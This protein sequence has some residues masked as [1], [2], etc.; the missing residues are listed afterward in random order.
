MNDDIPKGCLCYTK[1]VKGEIPKTFKKA[2]KILSKYKNNN[3]NIQDDDILDVIIRLYVAE[4][5]SNAIAMLQRCRINPNFGT[6][7]LRKDLEYFIPQ[8][9]NFMVFHQHLSDDNLIQFVLR[10]SSLDFF[11]AHQVFFQLKSMS[12][13]ITQ[14]EPVT[15]TIV[16]RFTD[17]FFLKMSQNYAG[18]LL[19]ASHIL[20]IDFEEINFNKNNLNTS[21]E[22][23]SPT[24]SS[25]QQVYQGGLRIE[26]IK[27]NDNISLYGTKEWN[28]N[29]NQ[30]SV[31]TAI[32]KNYKEIHLQ[33]YSSIFGKRQNNFDTAFFSN[34]SFWDDIMRICDDLSK[35]KK[36]TEFLH[37]CLQKMNE[38]LPAA[39]YVP[40]VGN[41]IRNHAVLK[42]VYKES[43]VFSTKM[44]SPF[45]LVL[46]LYRPEVEEKTNSQIVEEQISFPITAN[47]NI[48]KKPQER[49]QSHLLQEELKLD[50]IQRKYSSVDVQKSIQNEFMQLKFN[51]SKLPIDQNQL[52]GT[53]LFYC[54]N[55]ESLTSDIEQKDQNEI[56]KYST[57][58]SLQENV[59]AFSIEE[60]IPQVEKEEKDVLLISKMHRNS[61]LQAEKGITLNRDEYNELKRNIFG[62]SSQQQE[63][64]IKS[65][66]I[67]QGLK[68]WR[69]AHLIVKTGDNLKQEQFA[70]QLI[71]QFDQIF[72]KSGLPLKLRC[73][74]VLSLGPDCGII[75]MIKNATT[76]DSLQKNLR[77]KYQQFINFSD[78]FRSFF[79]NNI[80]QALQN[81]VQSLVAYGLVCYFLQVK[82]RHNGNILLDSEGHLIH[83]DFG[84]FLSNAPGKGM[85]FEGKVPFKLL[86]DYIQ[87]LGGAKGVLFKENFRKLFYKGFKACQQH[88][89]EILLLVEMMY[90]GHGTTL[91][92]FQKGEQALKELYARFNPRVKS[93]A[94][95]FV[96][97]QELINHSLDNW[98]ARWYDKFQYFAQ[99]V[100]Y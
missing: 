49:T 87:V 4:N 38:N 73:Y 1:K 89:K 27:V 100:F 46:E 65:Q 37:S 13:I 24:K 67:F 91:P 14:N 53:S 23:S 5:K 30:K 90:T 50:E 20:Q 32:L 45:S 85:E 40:F 2:N 28:K 18:N 95:L 66:S 15:F 55:D 29:D 26:S 94:E 62:E 19:I 68:S 44:R 64:R 98:R 25:L 17:N 57:T 3:L 97:V 47:S 86:S 9:V 48:K 7:L 69:L 59:Q 10:A 83:I 82:D 56:P 43:R 70:L 58:Y 60:N 54:L 42:I 76:I 33:D 74:E 41:S 99:G 11:F 52:N 61:F 77:K 80:D 71:S 96:H 72:K 31:E 12:Q 6:N 21:I 75:E 84:F 93:D 81:Y 88:Q 34:I 79:R 39:V 36:K 8:I 35:A 51:Q 78:F 92:C 16:R 63:D 22:T